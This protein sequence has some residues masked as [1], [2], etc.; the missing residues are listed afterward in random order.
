MRQ[1]GTVQGAV[2]EFELVE[3]HLDGAALRLEPLL[4]S[5]ETQRAEALFSWRNKHQAIKTRINFPRA[6]ARLAT[7]VRARVIKGQACGLETLRCTLK[8]AVSMRE[9]R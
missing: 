6:L 3:I 5:V 2:G 1:D 7:S 9:R 8:K 4:L